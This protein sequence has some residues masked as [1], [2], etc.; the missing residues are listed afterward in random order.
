MSETVTVESLPSWR[1]RAE[2]AGDRRRTGELE[3]AVVEW[4]GRGVACPQVEFLPDGELLAFC[5]ATLDGVRQEEM[6]VLLADLRE[7][8]LAIWQR[9]RLEEL[10]AGYRRGLVLKARALSEA[11][12][13]GLRPGLDDHAA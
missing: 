8:T 12:A 11:V 4:I 3:D 13:R 7:G 6:S 9:I 10:M 5:D 2:G 1:S